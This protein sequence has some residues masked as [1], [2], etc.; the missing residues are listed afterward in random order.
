MTLSLQPGQRLQQRLERIQRAITRCIEQAILEPETREQNRDAI[1]VLAQEVESL[2]HRPAPYQPPEPWQI[3]DDE[4]REL[5]INLTVTAAFATAPADHILTDCLIE[6]WQ[7]RLVQTAATGDADQWRHACQELNQDA[8]RIITLPPT[9]PLP[10]SRKSNRDVKTLL[11][12]ASQRLD[13]L[14]EILHHPDAAATLPFELACHHALTI[15]QD[16]IQWLG[17]ETH[18]RVDWT[19]PRPSDPTTVAAIKIMLNQHFQYTLQ[20]TAQLEALLTPTRQ[21]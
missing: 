18:T 2:V 9:P 14:F 13:N 19:H 20:Q 5:I 6:V 1:V 7:R 3:A 11:R 4:Q 16:T 10:T 12:D 8:R 15:M 21:S 17:D